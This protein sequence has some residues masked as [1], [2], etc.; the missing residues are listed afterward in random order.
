MQDEIECHNLKNVHFEKNGAEDK[1]HTI[2]L[3][4]MS[5]IHNFAHKMKIG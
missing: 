2:I 5:T 1:K 3:L 4:L